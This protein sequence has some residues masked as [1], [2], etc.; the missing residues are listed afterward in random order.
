LLLWLL[1][2]IQSLLFLDFQFLT[3]SSSSPPIF[4]TPFPTIRASADTESI[5]VGAAIASAFAESIG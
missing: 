1:F 2:P 4:S 3:L 5:E